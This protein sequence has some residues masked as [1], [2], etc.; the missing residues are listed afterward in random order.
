MIEQAVI[1]AAPLASRRVLLG[2]TLLQRAVLTLA[3]GGIRHILV[4]GPGPARPVGLE[5]DARLKAS[6]ATL[7]WAGTGESGAALPLAHAPFLLVDGRDVFTVGLV[8]WVLGLAA[9]KNQLLTPKVPPPGPGGVFSG[10]AVCQAGL[11]PR[12][13]ALP[14]SGDP[15]RELDF[16]PAAAPGETTAVPE[17][18]WVL[19]DSPE[20]AGRAGR[21]LRRS[22]GKPSDGF[23]SR[24]L[25][26]R[27]SWP[28]SRL[29][30]RLRVRPTQV[31]V[32]NLALGLLSGWLIGRG[33][34]GNTLAAGLLFQ[35]V[36][37]FDGCDGEI[38]RLTF[39]FSAFGTKLDNLCD[40]VTLVVFF[41][42]LPVGLYAA[43]AD[44]SY[45]VLGAAAVLEVAVFYLLLLARI[46]L[47]GHHGNI[48][49]VA[50]QVQEKDKTG[51]PLHWLE[52]LGVRLGFI[53]RKEFVSL[54]AMAWCI[55]DLAVVFL[56]TTV[57]LAS[58]GLVYEV[59]NL[60]QLASGR[61][62]S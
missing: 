60:W 15:A 9:D 17:H 25:N 43:S 52:R 14:A 42:N 3:H 59:H 61:R 16:L 22:M 58:V 4:L 51:K 1:L 41:I 62:G 11:F 6:G 57:M 13:L 44:V 19:V 37:I 23:F 40:F 56:W 29:L 27:I 39:R 10:L 18:S 26:R 31:T 46:K 54:Y 50:R 32:A 53:Y 20:A 30:V 48:A 5:D 7:Q 8:R 2:L 12:L 49:E 35:F 38:A 55:L 34:Y 47:S 21:L 24:H 33:G 36:S 28:M 45:L